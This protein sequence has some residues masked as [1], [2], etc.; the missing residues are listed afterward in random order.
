[1]VNPEN[2]GTVNPGGNIYVG[3]TA[4]GKADLEAYAYDIPKQPWGLNQTLM[5]IAGILAILVIVTPAVIIGWLSKRKP[6]A[7]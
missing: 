4:N 3:P 2:P 5:L 7:E 6:K 1:V